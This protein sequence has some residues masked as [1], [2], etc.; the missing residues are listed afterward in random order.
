MWELAPIRRKKPHSDK[1]TSRDLASDKSALTREL[2]DKHFQLDRLT[3]N[4]KEV[5]T[6]S[7]LPRQPRAAGCQFAA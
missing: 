3:G 4:I 5:E 7:G 1:R 6:R 2:G